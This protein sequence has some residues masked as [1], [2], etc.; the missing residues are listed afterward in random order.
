MGSLRRKSLHV[1]L[2]VPSHIILIKGDAMPK[3]DILKHYQCC[4]CKEEIEFSE[5]SPEMQAVMVESAERYRPKWRHVN[6]GMVVC[7][8]YA[9]PNANYPIEESNV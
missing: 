8:T 2:S 6:T 4:F 3:I 7:Q 1:L 9:K 5:A